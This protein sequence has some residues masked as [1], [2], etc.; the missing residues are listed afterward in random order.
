MT[1]KIIKK[2]S[3]LTIATA[4]AVTALT[5]SAKAAGFWTY[6]KDNWDD[7]S[8]GSMMEIFGMAYR[9]DAETVTFAINANTKL[10]GESE[11]LPGWAQD[12]VKDGNI[13]WGDL[14]LNLNPNQNINQSIASGEAIAIR[15]A[16]T[17]D[18]GVDGNVNTYSST[19][20]ET[21]VY[22]GISAKS[23]AGSNA[24]YSSLSKYEGQ[25]Y[26]SQ[27]QN[28]YGDNRLDKNY[29]GD[30]STKN[31]INTY[32]GRLGD[33]NLIDDI[34]SL[35]LDWTGQIGDEG[36]NTIAF[37]FDRSLLGE[38]QVD[39]IAHAFLE[40]LNDGIGMFGSFEAIPAPPPEVT[41]P[42]GDVEVPEPSAL[43]ALA[44][45]GL[46]LAGSHLKKQDC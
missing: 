13:G 20:G 14:F 35:G 37:S 8:G 7:G 44:L 6:Q 5:P 32:T 19:P 26:N 46:G 9:D 41:P 23:V 27:D 4:A 36:E 21:G 39:W 15:F 29:F 40:C 22:G 2:L 10:K 1:F 17:N 34:G 45:V 31:V 38:N 16:G 42:I 3:A 18:S 28:K 24:G 43:A 25:M 30:S 11:R 12:K 33:I